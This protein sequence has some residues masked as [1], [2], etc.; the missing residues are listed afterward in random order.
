LFTIFRLTQ[1]IRNAQDP[2]YA[3]WVD[4]IGDGLQDEVHIDDMLHV[5]RDTES[6][7]VFT[8]PDDVIQNL[9][10]C[11][12]RSI[13]APTNRQ[14]DRYN[15]Q[16]LAR[17]DEE[18]KTYVAADSLKEADDSGCMFPDSALDYLAR[19]TPPG[20]AEHKIKIKK[21]AV[22]RMLRNFSI[23]RQLV[24]N[25]RVLV[26]NLG[27]RLVTVRPLAARANSI[28]S[29]VEDVL[30]PRI[31][32]THELRSGHT[33][34]RRQLPL[35]YATTFNSCQ[36]LTLDRI[37]IDLT[38]PVFSHGQLYTALTRIRTR[39][40]GLVPLSEEETTSTNVTFRELLL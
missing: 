40:N 31:T 37:G 34:I 16:I 38:R 14:I 12:T 29:D 17:I 1:P 33:L 32:F 20:I 22:Y 7:I 24:K 35:A 27:T 15:D 28:R 9:S 2:V 30:I 13:L 5:V 18:E 23:D 11:V 26:I 3:E 36:G 6:L 4:E 8:F 25:A 39:E 21:N 19:N 10:A